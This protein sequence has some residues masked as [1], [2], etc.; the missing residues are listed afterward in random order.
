MWRLIEVSWGILHKTIQQ[1]VA[2]KTPISLPLTES[3]KTAASSKVVDATEKFQCC[4]RQMIVV[5]MVSSLGEILL[6]TTTQYNENVSKIFQARDVV[7][8]QSSWVIHHNPI[9]RCRV[10]RW[11]FSAGQHNSPHPLQDLMYEQV[12][13]IDLTSTCNQGS[14]HNLVISSYESLSTLKGGVMKLIS[15][16]AHHPWVAWHRCGVHP[17]PI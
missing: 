12:S 8:N 3:L 10:P 7:S 1:P 13:G 15:L 6:C 16:Q 9:S 11:A 17:F 4:C 5:W 2:P 14:G